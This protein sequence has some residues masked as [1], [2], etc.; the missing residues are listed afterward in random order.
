MSALSEAIH[1]LAGLP[2]S[3]LGDGESVVELHRQLARLEAVATRATAAFDASREWERDGAHTAAAWVTSRC[4]VPSAEARRRVRLGR[5]LRHLPA[6]EAAWL[7]GEVTGAHVG[8]LASARNDRTADLLAA[9]EEMLVDDARRLRFD[10]FVRVVRYWLQRADPDG[11]D[12]DEERRR[13]RRDVWLSESWEGMWFGKMTLDPTSGAVVWGELQRRERELFEA[14]W[15]EARARLGREPTVADLGRTAGQRRADALV[16]MAI[17]SAT[18]PA[19][20]RRPV[21]LFTVLVDYD[22]FAGRVCELANGSALAPA[23]LV[24]WLTQADIERAVFGSKTRVEVSAR[25]RLFKG[26]TR[27]AVQI[28]EREC[29]DE[30]CDVP[31]DDCE[32]DHIIPWTA[33]GPTT[34]A[35]GRPLCDYH[36]RRRERPPP[37]E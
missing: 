21:P 9:D 17:R 35:N 24:P 1:E 7:A 20:G 13:E 31:A 30:F 33:G 36:N 11:T 25:S 12:D 29:A 37:R 3:A 14:D 16:E 23:A 10:Q 4:Q 19:H 34:Q 8:V 27:R 2:P 6:A 18:V 5:M 15:K 26:A 22:T 32:V 28:R